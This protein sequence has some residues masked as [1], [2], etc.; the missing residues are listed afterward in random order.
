MYQKQIVRV[1]V[2]VITPRT[3]A[4]NGGLTSVLNLGL[5]ANCQVQ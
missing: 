2:T 5:A 1:N 4:S 3:M